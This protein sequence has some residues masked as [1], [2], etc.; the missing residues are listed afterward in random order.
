MMRSLV[1]VSAL[2]A[3]ACTHVAT[4]PSQYVG[5]PANGDALKGLSYSLPAL[6]YRI[7]VE[8]RLSACDTDSKPVFVTTPV[9]NS[10]YVSGE[11][12][13]VDPTALSSIMKTSSLKFAYHD[14]L[15]T[16][17]SFNAAADD[18][19]ADV[20]KD[21]ARVGIAVASTAMPALAPL[22]VGM[23]HGELPAGVGPSSILKLNQ[24]KL[25]AEQHIVCS[26]GAR[27]R[28]NA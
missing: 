8:R 22:A 11:R 28:I 12:F 20:L 7:E 4:I 9:A 3:G 21:V 13:E 17:K 16:L 27:A 6:S 18:K 15:D 24:G 26:P 5:R 2:L 10:T 19:S 25:F 1:L 14:D 23:P